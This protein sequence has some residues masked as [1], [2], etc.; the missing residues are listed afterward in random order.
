MT[1]DSQSSVKALKK[2]LV[3]YGFDKHLVKS[4]KG[5]KHLRESVYDRPKHNSSVDDHLGEVLSICEYLLLSTGVHR[6]SIG[7]NNGEVKTFSIFDPAN[8]E[9]H[10]AQDLLDTAYIADNFVEI[11][12]EEK[13]QFLK[14]LCTM[15]T[16]DKIF[17]YL[18]TRW[19]VDFKARNH[20]MKGVALTNVEEIK[21][22]LGIL[23]RLRNL[24]GYYLRSAS[25]G[26]FNSTV[27]MTFNCDG[28]HIVAHQ[29]FK[30]FIQE[31][32]L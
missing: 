15:L 20:S 14:R 19:Q 4:I 21:H 5:D 23:P 12:L 30:N 6:L 24:E 27:D 22:I 18:S 13:D 28:T 8:M 26:L 3:G 29:A 7:F 9:V 31:N 32:I 11:P 17:D 10:L 2:A 25:I 1:N 16:K